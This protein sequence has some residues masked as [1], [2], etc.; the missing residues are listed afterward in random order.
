MTCCY[1]C[2]SSFECSLK[3][4][5][6]FVPL[7]LH[8]EQY[9]LTDNFSTCRHFIQFASASVLPPPS[10]LASPLSHSLERERRLF[11][12]QKA[13]YTVTLSPYE[14][15]RSN[16]GGCDALA[17][18]I[19]LSP[20][21]MRVLA[22]K[23]VARQGLLFFSFEEGFLVPLLHGLAEVSWQE[24]YLDN[25]RWEAGLSFTDHVVKAVIA[26]QMPS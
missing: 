26:I 14:G 17:Q 8:V 21:G 16:G 23:Q 10:L 15:E 12:R 6:I 7:P 2:K 1:L 4:G 18:T 22:T 3:P 5:G 25:D 24:T 19:D 20:G 11:A 13:A 9:C